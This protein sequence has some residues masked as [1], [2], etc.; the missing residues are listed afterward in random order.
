MSWILA[1]FSKPVLSSTAQSLRQLHQLS[2][3]VRSIAPVSACVRFSPPSLSLSKAS[4]LSP[5]SPLLV[6]G[7]GIKHVAHP[8]KRC[9]HCYF[10]VKDEQLFVMCTANAKHYN[11]V[12]QKNKKWGNYVM[13]HATAGSTDKGRGRGS[14]HMNTQQ[15]FRLDY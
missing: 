4:L 3:S 1:H 6:P 5:S 15:S 14:R 8:K 7:S 2:S 12:R 10:Q 11:A 9:R 13:T